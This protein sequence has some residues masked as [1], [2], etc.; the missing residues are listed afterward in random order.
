MFA[1][2]WLNASNDEVVATVDR[3]IR[4][5][6]ESLRNN[7]A[8]VRSSEQKVLSLRAQHESFIQDFAAAEDRRSRRTTLGVVLMAITLAG[9]V[10]ALWW[11]TRN[12]RSKA[13]PGAAAD[14]AS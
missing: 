9:L 13:E 11:A 2:G 1:A 6:Q 12:D 8:E 4:V 7:P 5:Q 3:H 10:A 14:P